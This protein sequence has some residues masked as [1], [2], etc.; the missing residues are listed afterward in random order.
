[1]KIFLTQPRETRDA[2][3]PMAVL[4]LACYGRKFGHEIDVG[5]LDAKPLPVL[6][7]YDLVGVSAI[8]FDRSLVEFLQGIQAAYRGRV[9][10]GGKATDAM[11]DEDL[12]SVRRL[13]VEIFEGCGEG[14]LS[15]GVEVD[16]Q[17]YPVWSEVDFRIMD[18]AS[19]VT[20][21]MSSR[22]CPYR[23]HFCHNTEHRVRYFSPE[24]TAEH[25]KLILKTLGRFRVFFVDDIFALR[26]SHMRGV[27]AA[28]DAIGVDLRKHNDFFVH[29][30]QLDDAR[31]D[32]ID[33][34]QPRELQVGIESGDDGILAAMGKTFTAVE[35]ESKLREL[36]RRGHL[37]ACLFLMGFPGETSDSLQATVDFVTRNRKYMSGWWVSYYQPVPKTVGWELACERAGRRVDGNWNTDI[38]YLDPNITVEDLQAARKAVMG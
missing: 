7:C 31:L 13:G 6:D 17:Q 3:T 36:H 20:E 29:I 1:M 18:Y 19:S 10:L 16:Y 24:R 25:V 9:V 32:A 34:F 22:G 33:E 5:Y 2:R 8:Q 37:V 38:S 21:A 15:P 4:D 26:V 35:A 23:C 14:L 12:E 11:P 28:C 27:L 30:S